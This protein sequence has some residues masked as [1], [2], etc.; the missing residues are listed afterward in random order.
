MPELL[1]TS[2]TLI[3]SKVSVDKHAR[4]I[5]VPQ[6]RIE[7][8]RVDADTME[9]AVS[10][11][12]QEPRSNI[13]VQNVVCHFSTPQNSPQMYE[14]MQP[15]LALE[16]DEDP[17]EAQVQV[18]VVEDLVQLFVGQRDDTAK[19]YQLGIHAA[20]VKMEVGLHT[21]HH[22]LEAL[23]QQGLVTHPCRFIVI[24]AI[25]TTDFVVG[26]IRLWPTIAYE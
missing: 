22:E 6:Q 26:K 4:F 20:L 2:E 12:N 14:L 23:K 1:V 11:S 18:A 21:M 8:Y 16:A 7:G 13:Q 24:V 19:Q 5:D 17:T 9:Q 3:H 10:M 25:I 15:D